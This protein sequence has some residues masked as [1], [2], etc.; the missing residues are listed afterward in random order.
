M[1]LCLILLAGCGG[2]RSDLG[3]V[4]GVVLLA[5]QPLPDATVVFQ[6]D[7]GGPASFGRT[8][9][10]GR[11]ADPPVGRLGGSRQRERNGSQ[12]CLLRR[13]LGGRAAESA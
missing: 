6:P 11:Y 10:E 1:G 8:D 7:A 12:Q 5:G 9:A 2:G 13:Q 4:H 3:H